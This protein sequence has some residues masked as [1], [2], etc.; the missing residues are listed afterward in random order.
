MT[1]ISGSAEQ[2][3]KMYAVRLGTSFGLSVHSEKHLFS[4]IVLMNFSFFRKSGNEV[5]KRATD[6]TVVDHKAR[7]HSRDGDDHA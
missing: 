2:C 5:S 1:A 4:K 3:R 7:G 6:P